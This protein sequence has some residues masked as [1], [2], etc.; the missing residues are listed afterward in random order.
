MGRGVV[1]YWSVECRVI[2]GGGNCVQKNGKIADIC[3]RT[4]AYNNLK[5]YYQAKYWCWFFYYSAHIKQLGVS[6]C[7]NWGCVCS[8]TF[9]VDVKLSY[10]DSKCSN[11]KEIC[12]DRLSCWKTTVRHLI[13][14]PVWRRCINVCGEFSRLVIAWSLSNSSIN[15]IT[16]IL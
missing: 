15:C 3:K 9:D 6:L 13:M 10:Q 8:I 12:S 4:H 16:Y 2:G 14:R 1:C 11:R 7:V 5:W